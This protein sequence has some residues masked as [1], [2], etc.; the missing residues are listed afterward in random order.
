LA[1]TAYLHEGI[2]GWLPTFFA[3]LTMLQPIEA[4][5]RAEFAKILLGG[6]ADRSQPPQCNS[7][8]NREDFLSCVQSDYVS[9]GK[10]PS[11]WI[12]TGEF[13][14][15]IDKWGRCDNGFGF[16]DEK[17]LSLETPFGDRTALLLLHTDQ[18]HPLLGNGLL[19]ILKLPSASD[20][21]WASECSV[22]LNW[23]EAQTWTNPYPPLIGSWLASESPVRG[24]K[25]PA[26]VPTFCSFIPNLLYKPGLAENIVLYAPNR[27]RW[28][29]QSRWPNLSDLPMDAILAK[30]FNPQIVH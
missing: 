11:R 23:A 5:F 12:G 26:F 21:E 13:E 18:P 1:S 25:E 2:K 20:L 6:Q 28:A 8:N 24:E 27:V 29:R 19:S 4:Q 15:I 22:E 14:N 16:A 17:G 10:E 3:G 30:R 7:K 9:L